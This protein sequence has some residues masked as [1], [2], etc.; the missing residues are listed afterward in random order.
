MT[1][2]ELEYFPRKR[3]RYQMSKGWH[4]HSEGRLTDW[5]VLMHYVGTPC[6]MPVP[7]P[8]LTTRQQG[9]RSSSRVLTDRQK[10]RVWRLQRLKEL[11]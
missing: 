6:E 9:Y 1:E 7:E 5:A 2:H 10:L 3:V 8:K 4:V 11:A